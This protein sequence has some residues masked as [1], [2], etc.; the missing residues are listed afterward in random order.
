MK[1]KQRSLRVVDF[2]CNH[3][4][5]AQQTV[6]TESSFTVVGAGSE[7]GWKGAVD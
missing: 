7:G 1:L 3:K 6:I 2:I 5:M 4:T